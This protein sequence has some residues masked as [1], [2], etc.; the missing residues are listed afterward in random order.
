MSA[1]PNV[2]LLAPQIPVRSMSPF[3]DVLGQPV[4]SVI[5]REEYESIV[6]QLGFVQ[7]P[8]QTPHGCVDLNDKIAVPIGLA[9]AP[10]F[11]GRHPRSVWCIERGVKEERLVPRLLP[12][13]VDALLGKRRQ[14]VD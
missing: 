1:F 4:S 11:I 12:E 9:L 3:F 5:A 14:H 10:E 8:E 7:G 6:C 2:R 13:K